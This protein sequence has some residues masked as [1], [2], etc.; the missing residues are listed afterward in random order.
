MMKQLYNRFMP[1]FILTLTLSLLFS[2]AATA[3]PNP[4][5]ITTD[6]RIKTYVYNESEVF[7]VTIHYGYQSYIEFGKNERIETYSLGDASPWK[8]TTIKNRVFIT[9]VDGYAHTNMTVITSKHTYQFDLESKVPP[10]K[11][12]LTLTYAVRFYYP[13]DGFDRIKLTGAAEQ[14]SSIEVP[15]SGNKPYN[16]NYSFVGSDQIAPSKVFDDGASTYFE[17]PGTNMPL[18]SISII[19]YNGQE[20]TVGTKRHGQYIVVSRIAGQF[21]IRYGYDIICIFN[22]NNYSNPKG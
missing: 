15:L 8:I 3:T 6:S 7:P 5:P 22:E 14:Y 10:E 17:F 13:E 4:T 1:Y 9:P 11:E 20:V 21:A 16:F 18:P 19:D 12:D 2:V